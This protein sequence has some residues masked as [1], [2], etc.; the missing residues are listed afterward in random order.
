LL[1]I[2]TDANCPSEKKQCEFGDL[3]L[4]LLTHKPSGLLETS[5]I[6]GITAAIPSTATAAAATTPTTSSAAATAAATTTA[7]TRTLFAWA[8]FAD[9]QRT[10][11]KGK[12][13]EALDRFLAAFF[14]FHFDKAETLGA[15]RFAICNQRDFGDCASLTE[16]FADLFFGSAVS[17][18]ANV[19]LL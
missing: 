17:H 1:A 11:V 14:G 4:L 12:A 8:S 6:S 16:Q 2:D 7:A 19:Q 5:A 18:I 13:I 9:G 3:A 10:L 15:A